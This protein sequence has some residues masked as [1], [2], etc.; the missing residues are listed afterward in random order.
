MYTLNV[1]HKCIFVNNNWVLTTNLS[2]DCP[3]KTGLAGFSRIIF[4]VHGLHG[5]PRILFLFFC[6]AVYSE[7]LI[8]GMDFDISLMYVKNYL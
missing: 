1:Y 4:F 8:I 6:L 3:R 5:F 2:T 7:S